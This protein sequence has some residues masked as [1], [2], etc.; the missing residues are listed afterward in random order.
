MLCKKPWIVPIPGSTKPERIRENA[1]SAGI[2]LNRQE[3]EQ[4]DSLLDGMDFDVFGK[5]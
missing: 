5:K 1:A 2:M 4:M 3:L